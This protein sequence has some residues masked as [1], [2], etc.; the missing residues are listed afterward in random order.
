MDLGAVYNLKPKDHKK[1]KSSDF[2]AQERELVFDIDMTDYDD[3]RTCCSGAAICGKCWPFM[4]YAIKVV[5]AALQG[6]LL[7]SLS[8]FITSFFFFFD[9]SSCSCRWFRLS[10]PSL[11]I[12]RSSWGSLLGVRQACSRT[13]PGCANIFGFHPMF[14]LTHVCYRINGQRCPS[15]LHLSRWLLHSPLFWYHVSFF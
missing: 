7:C 11:G 13:E 8:P 5:D 14:L 2:I 1:I 12:L 3:L 10:S 6:I 4:T 9:L 15:T